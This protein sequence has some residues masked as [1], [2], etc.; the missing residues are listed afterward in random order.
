MLIIF[1][2]L[3]IL[4]FSGVVWVINRILPSG[5]CP[6]CAGVFLTWVWLVGAHLGGYQI[7]LTIPAFLM[8]GSVVG[9]MYQLE[10]KSRGASA[11]ARVLWK[12]LFVSGGFIAAYALLEQLWTVLL[13]AAVSLL[14]ISLVFLSFGRA[15]ETREETAKDIE[16]HMKECC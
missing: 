3:S 9:S 4:I 13:V 12:V 7:D 8:G 15:S 14:L 10:R 16:R 5:V 1:S 6:V 11:G 2:V